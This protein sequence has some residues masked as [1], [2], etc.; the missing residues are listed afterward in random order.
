[1]ETKETEQHTPTPWRLVSGEVWRD[2]TPIAR[3]DRDFGNG[4]TPEERD[5]NADRIVLAVNCH[6]DLLAACKAIMAL[7]DTGYLVRNTD[8]D[9]DSDWAMKQLGPV[10]DMQ[11]AQAAIAKAETKPTC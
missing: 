1:M 5:A 4:T 8:Q 2:N 10:K 9:S 3:M 11:S 7:I 6:D